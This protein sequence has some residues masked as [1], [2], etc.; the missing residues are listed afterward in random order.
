MIQSMCKNSLFSPSCFLDGHKAES[1][2][3]MDDE[4]LRPM[5][6]VHIS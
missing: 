6:I 5:E 1:T 3:G 4:S 2:F